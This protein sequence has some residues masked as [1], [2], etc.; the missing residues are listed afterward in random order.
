MNTAS[1]GMS[2]TCSSNSVQVLVEMGFSAFAALLIT[3]RTM[4]VMRSR[5]FFVRGEYELSGF[6]VVRQFQVGERPA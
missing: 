3:F 4:V 6:D 1:S 5:R 2:M